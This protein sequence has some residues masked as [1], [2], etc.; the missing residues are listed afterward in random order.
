MWLLVVVCFTAFTPDPLDLIAVDADATMMFTAPQASGL[1][2]GIA[3]PDVPCYKGVARGLPARLYSQ[4][5][6][7]NILH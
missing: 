3:M 2:R 6:T 1:N 4:R 7:S 5:I